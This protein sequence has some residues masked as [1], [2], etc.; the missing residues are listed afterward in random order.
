[1]RP[2]RWDSEENPFVLELYPATGGDRGDALL[3]S[4][5]CL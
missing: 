1:M 3:S 5:G 2:K 4:R